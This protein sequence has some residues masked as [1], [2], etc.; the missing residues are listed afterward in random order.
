MGDMI[1]RNY[2]KQ[3]ETSIVNMTSGKYSDELKGYS[4]EKIMIA[5]YEGIVG[6]YSYVSSGAVGYFFVFVY[7]APEYRRRNVGT[8]LYL[9]AEKR[10][11]KAEC[12]EIFTTYY[13]KD[14][15]EKFVKKLGA[16]YTTSSHIMKY[17]GG[18]ISEKEMTIRQYKDEDY[19]RFHYIWSYGSHEMHKRIGLPVKEPF[20]MEEIYREQYHNDRDNLYVLERDGQIIGVGG[21][22]G[23]S[24][25]CLAVDIH[26]NNHGYGTALAAYLT[27]Q[28]IQR[29]N[30]EVYVTC[31][32]GNDNALHIYEKIGYKKLYREYWA[33]KRF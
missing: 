25:G 18:L 29:G 15:T 3:D 2:M 28:I 22:L 16:T 5:E 27:N 12:N 9:E 21:I 20:K 4:R 19:L 17:S 6:G 33:I 26:Y 13:E 31:E 10:C 7:V 14:G 11:L 8:K 30:N 23:N 1:I 24:I 32:I